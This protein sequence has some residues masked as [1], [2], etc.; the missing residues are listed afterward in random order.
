MRANTRTETH[1]ALPATLPEFR[2]FATFL[3]WKTVLF[4]HSLR[5]TGRGK[6]FS[7]SQYA[8]FASYVRAT[9]YTFTFHVHNAATFR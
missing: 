2:Y 8:C 9:T 5:L 3:I 6:R 4:R 1:A 7:G